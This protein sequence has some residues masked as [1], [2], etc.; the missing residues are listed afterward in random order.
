MLGSNSPHLTALTLVKIFAC[1]VNV[2]NILGQRHETF[3]H[4]GERC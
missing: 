3:R 2:V 4:P 1:G